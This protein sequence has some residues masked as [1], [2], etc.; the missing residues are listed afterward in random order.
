[1]DGGN[2]RAN[3]A[4]AADGELGADPAAGGLDEGGSDSESDA[5]RGSTL[6]DGV[7]AA[8]F[9]AESVAAV[10]DP[11]PDRSDSAGPGEVGG[12]GVELPSNGAGYQIGKPPDDFISNRGSRP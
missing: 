1:L 9:G 11:G 2:A 6:G 4:T 12:E 10:G 7:D 5:L 8:E 3:G